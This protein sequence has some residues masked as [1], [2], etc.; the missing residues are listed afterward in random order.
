[1]LVLVAM[2][3]AARA[4]TDESESAS[5]G[6]AAL[7]DR[8][9]ANHDDVDRGRRSLGRESVSFSIGWCGGA[10]TNHDQALSRE[11]FLASLVPTRP[12]KPMEAK[13]PAT[14]PQANAV[15]Y[16]LLTMDKN[17]NA[18]IEKDEVPSELRRRPTA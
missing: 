6:D 9:D 14:L 1:M 8:L 4:E 18:R 2:T 11:E 3:N 10:T 16:L 12:E 15:R 17:R 5:A 7:F 13:E